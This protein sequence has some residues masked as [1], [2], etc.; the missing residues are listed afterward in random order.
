[1][2]LT[3]IILHTWVKFS[4]TYK[5]SIRGQSHECEKQLA[6]GQ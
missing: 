3:F 1:M 6:K 5:H 2:G 4:L